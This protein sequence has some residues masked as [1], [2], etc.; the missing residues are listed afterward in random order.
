MNIILMVTKLATFVLG[1]FGVLN[2]QKTGEFIALNDL[3]YWDVDEQKAFKGPDQAGEHA[4]EKHWFK[5]Q[6]KK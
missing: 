1:M 4:R 5:S 3:T 6:V 2:V